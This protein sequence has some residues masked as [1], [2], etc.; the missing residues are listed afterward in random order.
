[1]NSILV[2]DWTRLLD[3][4][5]QVT[6]LV[7]SRAK[8]NLINYVYVMQWKLQLTLAILSTLSFLDNNDHYCYDVY[9]LI[10]HLIDS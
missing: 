7:D 5:R 2:K 9:E 3:D 1:M 4:E 8:L 6:N 10:Y